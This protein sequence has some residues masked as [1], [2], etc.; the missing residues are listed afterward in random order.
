[1]LSGVLSAMG[2]GMP[3][4]CELALKQDPASFRLYD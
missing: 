2:S 4:P 1:M 3:D